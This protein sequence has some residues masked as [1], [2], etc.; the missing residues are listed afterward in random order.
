M[1]RFSDPTGTLPGPSDC[2]WY[3]DY[4]EVHMTKQSKCWV[5][6]PEKSIAIGV[7]FERYS[8]LI[9]ASGLVKDLFRNT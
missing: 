6:L 7:V 3:L 1:A 8:S 5:N 4:L 2:K 9:M